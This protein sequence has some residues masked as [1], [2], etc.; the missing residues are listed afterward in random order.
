MALL[1]ANAVPQSPQKRLPG[2]F[3]AP[4][5]EQRLVNGAPQSLQNLFPV[6]FSLPNLGQRIGS[7]VGQPIRTHLSP[8]RDGDYCS[9]RQAISVRK[10]IG[11]DARGRH[12]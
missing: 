8:C 2:G 10:A 11:T 4:H 3:S 6:G 1:A 5:L 12:P 7:P 9:V